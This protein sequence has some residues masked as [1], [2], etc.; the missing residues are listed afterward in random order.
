MHYTSVAL[1][2]VA[3]PKMNIEELAKAEEMY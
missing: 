1:R 2:T 3:A